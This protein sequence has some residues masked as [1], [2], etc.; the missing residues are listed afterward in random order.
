M[1]RFASTAEYSDTLRAF[2]LKVYNKNFYF[3]SPENDT[4]SYTEYV[5]FYNEIT[6]P[7]D[8]KNAVIRRHFHRSYRV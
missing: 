7:V 2:G 6:N 3:I 8:N 5:K 1:I 4:M